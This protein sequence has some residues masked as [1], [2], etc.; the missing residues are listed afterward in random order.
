MARAG[1]GPVAL[2][3]RT[4]VLALAALVLAAI[5]GGVVGGLIVHWAF[6]RAT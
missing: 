4:L 5:V 3:G 1:A 6:A 2:R